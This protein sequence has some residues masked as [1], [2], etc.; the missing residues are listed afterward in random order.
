MIFFENRQ[1]K[2]FFKTSGKFFVTSKMKQNPSSCSIGIWNYHL[3]PSKLK[4]RIFLCPYAS[5]L[6]CA[7]KI[8]IIFLTSSKER[9][10]E[11]HIWSNLQL[12][13]RKKSFGFDFDFQIFSGFH[14]SRVD[15]QIL[16]CKSLEMYGHNFRNFSQS[17]PLHVSVFLH[18]L[19]CK[20]SSRGFQSHQNKFL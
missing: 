4:S 19:L 6:C 18:L 14:E 11:N 5:P 7:A 1:K 20:F 9:A 10:K 8:G 3:A 16:G 12:E 2:Y 17:Q 15:K 13:G